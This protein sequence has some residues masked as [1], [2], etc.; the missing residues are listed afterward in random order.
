MI[1]DLGSYID[2]LDRI[3]GLIKVD[4]EVSPELEITA[5]TDKA[6]RSKRYDSKAL[7]FNKVS[8][9]DM[10]VATNLFGSTT[11]LKELF[12]NTYANEVLAN[13]NKL[14]SNEFKPSLIKGAKALMNSKPKISGMKEGSFKRISG[15][16]ELP[17]LKVWPKDA[18]KFITL[19]LVVTRSPMDNSLNV[20]L[21]RMQVYD[22]ETTGMHWQAQKGGAIHASQALEKGEE[23]KVSVAIGTDPYN[24][25]SAVAPLPQGINEFSISGIARN[26]KTLLMQ[27]KDYPPVP[28]NADIVLYG[29][30]DPREKR[31]EG[32]FGDHTGYYSIPEDYPVFHI[33]RMYAKKRA[34]YPASVVGF[35]W[36]EDVV[37][38][39]FL[40]D[41][42]KPVIKSMNEAIVDIYLPPEGV[43]TEMCFVSIKKRFPGEAKKVM[44]SIL[45][46]GQLSFMKI[47]AVFDDD[48]DLRDT[49]K[50][51]W[52]LATRVEPQRD[53]QIITGAAADSLDHTTSL[54]DYGSKL[55]IDATKKTKGEGYP[56]E[57][58]DM[59][60][61]PEELVKEVER[62][63]A[64]LKK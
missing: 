48:I 18:G 63:W 13:F 8:G 39:Q 12:S 47:I 23:L 17:I 59:I 3:N 21:Y 38:G 4:H 29:R 37:I 14:K 22:G 43:F 20:G 49:S 56:R 57:W 11:V 19:P 55:L 32:P 36:H 6:G 30:V 58:P 10:K 2:Y 26:S 24:I 64:S 7:L 41:Y 33:D 62:K 60:S 25:I 15:L 44:F 5:F 51:M 52:A 28:E 35:S 27:Y 53:V 46:T 34:I 1:S 40:F 50:V 42:F 9:Y 61:L 45:G 16:D 31:K 54:P